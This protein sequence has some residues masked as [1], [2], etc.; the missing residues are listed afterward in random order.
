MSL[1]SRQ[2]PEA[3]PACCWLLVKLSRPW[4]VTEFLWSLLA[5]VFLHERHTINQ[6][7]LGKAQAARLTMQQLSRE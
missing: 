3:A 7:Y 4:K 2:L 5:G 1:L 6:E